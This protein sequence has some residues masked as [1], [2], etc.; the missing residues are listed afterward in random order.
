MNAYHREEVQRM[1]PAYGMAEMPRPNCHDD[2]VCYRIKPGPAGPRGPQGL[3]G[4]DGTPGPMGSM[5]PVGPAGPMGPCGP[6]GLPGYDGKHGVTG[7]MGHMGPRG[8][9]GPKGDKGDAGPMG[10]AGCAGPVGPA[11]PTEMYMATSAPCV[12]P[13]YHTAKRIV[14]ECPQGMTCIS[15]GC[16]SRALAVTHSAP[17]DGYRGWEVSCYNNT[18]CAI[19][20]QCYAICVPNNC[21]KPVAGPRGACSSCDVK[22]VPCQRPQYPLYD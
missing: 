10:A 9:A 8:H 11:G 13:P 3:P 7:P 19:T 14:A 2:Y 4:L 6:Q 5:G 20:V 18:D 15:G 21:V 22:P 16:N 1:N 17:V 12:V